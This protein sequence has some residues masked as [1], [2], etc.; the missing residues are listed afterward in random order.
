MTKD[1]TAEEA[2][3]ISRESYSWSGIMGHIEMIARKYPAH[4]YIKGY[5]PNRFPA[6][7]VVR[8]C[9]LGYKVTV[10]DDEVTVSWEEDES[11]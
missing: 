9:D 1:I 2:R 10:T 3:A 5:R 8:L 7:Y 4:S 11:I 6:E